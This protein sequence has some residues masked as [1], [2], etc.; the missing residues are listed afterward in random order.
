MRMRYPA[1]NALAPADKGQGLFLD[2]ART[3]SPGFVHAKRVLSTG[4]EGFFIMTCQDLQTVY[5]NS[6][7]LHIQVTHVGPYAPSD[8]N[9]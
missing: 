6:H 3:G 5:N 4:S 1:E 8:P 2:G 9:P 7:C